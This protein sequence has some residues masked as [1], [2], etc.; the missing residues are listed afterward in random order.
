MLV[1]PLIFHALI[2][3]EN[4]WSIH[5]VRR[6]S[7]PSHWHPVGDIFIISYKIQIFAGVCCNINQAVRNQL[8]TV[9]A[10]IQSQC[11]QCRICEG[12]TGAGA[13]LFSTSAFSCQLSFQ[14]CFILIYHHGPA[15]PAALP[16][17][18]VSPHYHVQKNFYEIL[19]IL[20]QKFS[21]WKFV[22]RVWY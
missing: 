1:K 19:I 5:S 8:L 4:T 2:T 17:H 15:E 6:C 20:T 3:T 12:H 22:I 10:H 16:R 9:K 18:S 13:G 11:C 14:L 7:I 21:I